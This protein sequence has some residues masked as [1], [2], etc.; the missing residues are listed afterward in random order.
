M[1]QELLRLERL[2]KY[3]TGARSVVVGLSDIDLS[4]SAGEFVAVTGESGSGKSTLA[5]VICG[6]LPYESGEMWVEGRQTA[7]YDGGD[8]ERYRREKISYIAQNYGILP[9]STVLGNVVSALKIT[10]L[11]RVQAAQRAEELL[12][13]V[14][15]WDLRNRRAAKLSSGQKQRLS[16]ARALA[17]PAPILVADEP[18]GN[19]DGENSAKVIELLARAAQDR[20]VILITHDFQ[21]ADGYVTRRIELQDG[22]VV[23]D[24]PLQPRLEMTRHPQTANRK[25]I[26]SP[27]IGK[28][29]IAGRPVWSILVGLFFTLTAFAVFAFLGTFFVNLD[30]TFT[31]IYDTSAFLNGDK[32]RIVVQRMDSQPLEQEDWEKIANVTYARGLERNSYMADWQYAWQQD[33]DYQLHYTIES[34][35]DPMD[36]VKEVVSS[37]ELLTEQCAFLQTVPVLPEGQTFLTAGRLP[38]TMYEVVQAGDESC[39]GQTFPVYLRDE[40]TMATGAYVKIQVTVVGT[41]DYGTGLYF[42]DELSRVIYQY[43][44]NGGLESAALLV[45]PVYDTLIETLDEAVFQQKYGFTDLPTEPGQICIESLYTTSVESGRYTL[46]TFP[47]EKIPVTIYDGEDTE[48]ENGTSMVLSSTGYLGNSSP[49][50]NWCAIYTEDEKMPVLELDRDAL[51]ALGQTEEA[52]TDGEMNVIADALSKVRFHVREEDGRRVVDVYLYSDN[53]MATSENW[54]QHYSM[55]LGDIQLRADV[56]HDSQFNA[57]VLVTDF[58]FDRYATN[59]N[60]NQAS[61]YIT[62]YAYTDRVLEE[63]GDLGYMAVSPFREGATTKNQTLASERMR[64]LIVCLTALAAVILLQLLVLKELFAVEHDSY[65]LLSDMGLSRKAARYSLLW[66]ALL[67]AVLGQILAFGS[68]L[69][70]GLWGVERI[71]SILRYLPAGKWLVLSGVHLALSLFTGWIVMNAMAKKVYPQ[72]GERGDLELDGEG[73]V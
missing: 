37:V 31:R 62:D 5:Q 16:I 12:K 48:K 39:I 10:G 3:Y 64:T 60:P 59:D 35:G 11:D 30:D 73:N 19:L 53:A 65:R 7:H 6:I 25:K 4:F 8:W 58:V 67:F 71:E 1:E 46:W 40:R 42:G 34:L 45:A 13:M 29:Q 15:L 9:G 17:K 49:V 32:T 38:E 70:C 44:L 51:T 47:L 54:F 50:Q 24:V 14:E 36:P 33:V 21:E 55:V 56:C 26:L 63:L 18:T 68:T 61:L 69:L 23:R 28:L 72:T 43:V 2:S 66:Q 41:T 22:K 27:Y 20:L 57:Y 52:L